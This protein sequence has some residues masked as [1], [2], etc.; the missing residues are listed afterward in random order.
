MDPGMFVLPK[1]LVDL[2]TRS[3]TF[4]GGLHLYEQLPTCDG[5]TMDMR[6]NTPPDLR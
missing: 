4:D 1:R 3:T 2:R 6:S 5:G